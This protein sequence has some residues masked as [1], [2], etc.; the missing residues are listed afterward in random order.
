M[1]GSVGK[2]SDERR[3]EDSPD[4]N[5]SM[6]SASMAVKM[7]WYAH[8]C[9][10]T[11]LLDDVVREHE[12]RKWEEERENAVLDQITWMSPDHSHMAAPAR[13]ALLWDDTRA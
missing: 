11:G 3:C 1:E 6:C 9:C 10:P 5:S 8:T 12:E 4:S 2:M 7:R 13:R